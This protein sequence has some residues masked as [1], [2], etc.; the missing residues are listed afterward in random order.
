MFICIYNCVDAIFPLPLLSHPHSRAQWG[1]VWQCKPDLG[2]R[3]SAGMNNSLCSGW[4]APANGRHTL[5]QTAGLP[6]MSLSRLSQIV[7][8]L[9]HPFSNAQSPYARSLWAANGHNSVTAQ[10]HLLIKTKTQLQQCKLVIFPLR[11]VVNVCDTPRLFFTFVCFLLESWRNH[12]SLTFHLLQFINAWKQL[13]H[14][15]NPTQ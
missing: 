12:L 9:N 1:S 11:V 7:L 10:R 15:N 2:S 14:M 5:E 6:L 3:V 4:C 8:V 13:L